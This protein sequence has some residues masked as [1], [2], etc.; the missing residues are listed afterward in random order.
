MRNR[1]KEGHLTNKMNELVSFNTKIEND[2][3]CL[4]DQKRD[5]GDMEIG[6]FLLSFIV[7]DMVE[8]F[9]P[10]LSR[11][12][13]LLHDAEWYLGYYGVLSPETYPERLSEAR[14]VDFRIYLT[15]QERKKAMIQFCEEQKVAQQ[16]GEHP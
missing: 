9:M 16:Y 6:L 2:I 1:S 7:H 15:S 5:E 3:K 10:K 4:M 13:K 8:N 12:E 11:M 14:T